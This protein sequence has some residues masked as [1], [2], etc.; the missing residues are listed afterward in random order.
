MRKH[1]DVGN[2]WYTLYR[3]LIKGFIQLNLL[4]AGSV[5]WWL[6]DIFFHFDLIVWIQFRQNGTAKMGCKEV[7]DRCVSLRS[8][9]LLSARWKSCR[10]CIRPVVVCIVKRSVLFITNM[11]SKIGAFSCW[12]PVRDQI[13]E[14]RHLYYYI[15]QCGS[16]SK[17]QK[18]HAVLS[19]PHEDIGN[20]PF[21]ICCSLLEPCAQVRPQ[22]PFSYPFW[23]MNH[24]QHPLHLMCWF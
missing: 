13:C 17:F 15:L 14:G 11:M 12:G 24:S 18:V 23:M 8:Q 16:L 10:Y 2:V 9:L 5:F 21:L 1:Y 6:T 19:K 3:F 4:F 7:E 22:I 20:S